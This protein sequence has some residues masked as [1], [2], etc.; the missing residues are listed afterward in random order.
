[1]EPSGTIDARFWELTDAL[2]RAHPLTIDRPRGS[3]HPRRPDIV[4]PLDY[5]YLEGTGT[6][7][8]WRGSLSEVRVS[9]RIVT[10]D[11]A[12]RDAE[13]QLLVGCTPGETRIVL[14]A[15]IRWNSQ[16]GMLLARP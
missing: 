2:V 4:Y 11:I 7:D 15:H 9:A 14:A 13:V 12:K 5:C 3:A 16:T 6:V 8:V 1:M 10:V